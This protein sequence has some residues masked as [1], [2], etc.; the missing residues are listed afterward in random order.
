MSPLRARRVVRGGLGEILAAEK[1]DLQLRLPKTDI[2]D[3]FDAIDSSGRNVR[4]RCDL[5]DTTAIHKDATGGI[6]L[7]RIFHAM[8]EISGLRPEKL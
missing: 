7:A 8:H 3:V 1:Y 4:I 2:V 5:L 6:L